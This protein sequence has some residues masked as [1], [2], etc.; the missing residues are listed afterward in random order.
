MSSVIARPLVSFSSFTVHTCNRC[1][2]TLIYFWDLRL[3]NA[4]MRI[5]RGVVL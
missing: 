5:F 1:S 3:R 4:A 2:F